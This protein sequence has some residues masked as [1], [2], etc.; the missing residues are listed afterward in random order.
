METH[1]TGQCEGRRGNPLPANDKSGPPR[2]EMVSIM[3]VL[4]PLFQQDLIQP[5][6]NVDANGAGR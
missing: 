2:F 5:A 3:I 4:L 6:K 1:K